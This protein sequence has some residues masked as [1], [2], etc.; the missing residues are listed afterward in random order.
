M[1]VMYLREELG[2][3]GTS[4]TYLTGMHLESQHEQQTVM[5]RM[6]Q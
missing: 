2:V 6:I 3:S 1:T 5:K 4:L